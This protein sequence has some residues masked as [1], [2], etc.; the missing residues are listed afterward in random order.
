MKGIRRIRQRLCALPL[1]L[2]CL[3]GLAACG[4]PD[5]GSFSKELEFGDKQISDTQ[6]TYV[7]KIPEGKLG[8]LIG[9]SQ[10][11][12][13]IDQ[14]GDPPAHTGAVAVGTKKAAKDLLRKSPELQCRALENTY[15]EES[16]DEGKWEYKDSSCRKQRKLSWL[17]KTL[18]N[19]YQVQSDSTIEWLSTS[20]N[21]LVAANDTVSTLQANA[22]PNYDSWFA[23]V[24]RYLRIAQ[25]VLVAAAAISLIVLSARIVWNIGQGGEGRLLD[26]I[27][28]ILLGV[29]LGSSC[30]SIALTFFSRSS[31]GNPDLPSWTPGGGTTFFLSDYIRMQ[32]DPFLIIAA[33]CGVIAAGW[34][35]V[36]QQEGRDLIPL[37]KAFMWAILS[38]VCLA[39][40]VNTFQA[41]F[42]TWT[43][44]VLRSAS[45]M[46]NDAW[47]SKSLAASSFFNLG[48]PVAIVL[49]IVMWICGLISKIF[50]YFRAGMLPIL[51]GVAPMWAAMS[52]MET[53][54]QAFAKTIGWLAAFLAY[55]PV[56][57]LVM[58]TGSAIMATAGPGDDSQAI[59]LM[60][61]LSVIILLPAMIR[62]IVPAVQ[63]SVGGGGGGI[64][65]SILGMGVAV[66]GGG[67]RKA[68]GGKGG[69]KGGDSGGGEASPDGAK[70][71]AGRGLAGLLSGLG[72][73]DGKPQ[74]TNGFAGIGHDAGDEAHLNA[75]QQSR[76]RLAATWTGST[77]TF[78][79]D[80]SNP[81]G[82]TDGSRMTFGAPV[83]RTAVLTYD[84][85]AADASGQVPSNTTPDTTQTASS[86]STGKVSDLVQ[87][88]TTH[89]DGS[90]TVKTIDTS[91]DVVSGCQ[92]YYPAGQKITLATMAKDDDCWDS[93]M[94]SRPGHTQLGWNQ[95]RNATQAQAQVTMV[96]G[97]MTV[98]AVWVG[99]PVL[100]YDTNKPSTWSGQMPSTPASVSVPYNAP[101][102]DGS[103]WRAGDTTKIRGYRFL[104]WYTGPQ[105]NAGLYDWTRPLTGSVTVYAHW[106]RL[107][108]NVVYNANGGTGSHPNTT[109]WQYSDVTIPGDTSK[110]FKRD[111][112][113]FKGWGTKPGKAD[114]AYKDGSKVALQDK[115]I[116]LYAQWQEVHENF[117]ETGRYRPADRH[118]GRRPAAHV[119]HR[120]DRHAHQTHERTRH[121]G[122][123]VTGTR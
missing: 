87:R 43:A 54:K 27:G 112:Y 75:P 107:Q 20:R 103:G 23:P 34:K 56:A 90:V 98:Y 66:A 86:K 10:I 4:G 70:P 51:V 113:V 31:G 100:T 64:L 116:T 50:A 15:Q 67:L 49:T 55:K 74:G 85:N 96:E 3:M 47:E 106:Q 44:D 102:A 115:D 99:N 65:P 97:G 11:Q 14:Y 29:L 94:L 13:V 118:R 16:S 91:T 19:M 79:Y 18:W 110:S 109:G 93:S 28:W 69:R 61:T 36:T 80:L 81:A 12:W 71:G 57:A 46:M 63:S 38:A 53:G 77:F 104:G 105:D 24:N 68:M 121:A 2:A 83:T 119:R 111:K 60:L 82:R 35:L 41:T 76:H 123:R 95:D 72:R 32:V 21:T 59:T 52:W 39:G 108:A 84:K 9:P 26:R 48:A 6:T 30:A 58:A 73:G 62:V 5:F 89:E 88:T 101:A 7:M 45:G 117:V 22:T 17:E 114:V 122:Q 78:S 25:G 120:L 8:D 92:V 40:L 42:D 1:A 37:G 33:V